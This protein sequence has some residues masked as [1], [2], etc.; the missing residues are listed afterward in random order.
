[1]ENKMMM[2]ACYSVMTEDEMTYTSGGDAGTAYAVG[3]V[4]GT[5]FSIAN[6]VWGIGKSREWIQKNKKGKSVTELAASGIDAFA[7]Y[8]NKSV[9]NA[10]VGVYT[11]INLAGWWPVT[12]VAWVTA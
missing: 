11:A 5:T 7:N 10:V 9:G 1:M 3:W 8:L 4:I 6:M 2:P 12:A